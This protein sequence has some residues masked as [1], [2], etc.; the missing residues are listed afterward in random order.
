MSAEGGESDVVFNSPAS[1]WMGTSGKS[2]SPFLVMAGEWNLIFG[3]LRPIIRS[4]YASPVIKALFSTS[5]Q[6]SR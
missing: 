5:A 3:L 1:R 4:T 6:S 2:S